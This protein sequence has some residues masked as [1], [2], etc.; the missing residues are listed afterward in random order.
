MILHILNRPPS[1]SQVYRQALAAMAEEDRLLLIED[2]VMG[3]LSAQ[4]EHFQPVT[5]R[6]FVLSEDLES[7]GLEAHCAAEIH[8]INIDG[9]VALTEEANKTVSWF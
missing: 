9:F 6:L 4:I 8:K 3:A 1:L 2:G 7:R 5:G